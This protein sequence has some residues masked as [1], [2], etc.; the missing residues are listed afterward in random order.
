MEAVRVRAANLPAIGRLFGSPA[1]PITLTFPWL[2]LA[3]FI[4]LPVKFHIHY[5]EPM[6]FSGDPTEDDASIEKKV[7]Q[8]KDAIRG[9]VGTAREERRSWFT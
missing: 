2:G 3:G 5:G 1:F 4:P 7:D 6:H 9:L 8:V